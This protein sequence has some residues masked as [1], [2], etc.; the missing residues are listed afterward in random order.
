MAGESG[1]P[2]VNI[3]DCECPGAPHSGGDLVWLRPK[4]DLN[5]GLAV[6]EALRQ[7]GSLRGDGQAAVLSAMVRYGVAAWNI[8]DEDGSVPITTDAVAQ[9]LGWG[10]GAL[11]VTAKAR[12]LYWER[13][14]SPLGLTRS[15]SAPATP[16]EPSTSPSPAS[17]RNTPTSSEP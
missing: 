6:Q 15:T 8:R 4:P 2:E 10:E 9:R 16:D 11:K 14:L 12:E 3:G 5:M 13:V 17:G 7:S 1:P